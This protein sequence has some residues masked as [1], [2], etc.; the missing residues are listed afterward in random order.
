MCET[1]RRGEAPR[2]RAGA[3][4]LDHRAQPLRN[5]DFAEG[6]AADLAPIDRARTWQLSPFSS[7][8]P[9]GFLR[10]APGFARFSTDNGGRRWDPQNPLPPAGSRCGDR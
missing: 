4:G 3:P 8:S 7:I 6:F 2:I 1:P 5:R 9:G 10:S